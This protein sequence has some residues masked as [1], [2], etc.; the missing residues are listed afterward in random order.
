MARHQRYSKRSR[1]SRKAM[2]NGPAA[3]VDYPDRAE[4]G[5]DEWPHAPDD[6]GAPLHSP[7]RPPRRGIN[8]QVQ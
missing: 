2:A 5:G 6:G 3:D 4:R 8:R 7:P 1:E